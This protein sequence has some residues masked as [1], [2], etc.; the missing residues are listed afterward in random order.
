MVKG[1]N[2]YW[3]SKA[4]GGLMFTHFS[5]LNDHDR[6][7]MSIFLK[8]TTDAYCNWSYVVKFHTSSSALPKMNMA[9][10]QCIITV[11]TLQ[12]DRYIITL[13]GLNIMIVWP[14]AGSV[15]H[16]VIHGLGLCDLWVATS[17]S[18]GTSLA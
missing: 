13:G 9:D 17:L 3:L 12:V 11:S 4:S 5:F 2:S 1:S 14:D 16:P 15:Q 18:L 7:T 8:E 6:Q 10:H